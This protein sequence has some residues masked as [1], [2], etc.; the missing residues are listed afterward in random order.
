M[1]ASVTWEP[2]RIVDRAEAWRIQAMLEIADRTSG[3]ATGAD[4]S[5]VIDA[6]GWFEREY[7]GGGAPLLRALLETYV[8]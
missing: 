3:T 7:A 5:V 8:D 4:M 1:R 2:V 6:P